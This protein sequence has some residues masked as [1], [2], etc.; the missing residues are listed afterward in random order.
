MP[1]ICFPAQSYSIQPIYRWLA[2]TQIVDIIGKIKLKLTLNDPA[3]RL[4]TFQLLSQIDIETYS[5]GCNWLDG[6]TP[7]WPLLHNL[8]RRRGI[9]ANQ[10]WQE[11]ERQKHQQWQSHWLIQHYHQ[12]HKS[13]HPRQ[14]HTL[15][16]QNTF[17][18]YLIPSYFSLYGP[19]ILFPLNNL[20]PYLLLPMIKNKDKE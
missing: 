8:T 9:A 15:Q 13:K 3:G 6:T 4:Q 7:S 20:L 2:S 1:T 16:L 17:T 5:I 18:P 12:Q 10:H 14:F 11:Q 19:Y